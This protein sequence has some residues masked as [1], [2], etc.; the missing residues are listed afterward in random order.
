MNKPRLINISMNNKRC[1]FWKK[2][3]KKEI[4]FQNNLLTD[5]PWN[6]LQKQKQKKKT[7]F[8]NPIT[9]REKR[10]WNFSDKHSKTC[11]YSYIFLCI[12]SGLGLI[13]LN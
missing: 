11:F 10:L 8:S 7:S 9:I 3:K 1:D 6:E 2:K 13:S 12:D 4:S 5:I